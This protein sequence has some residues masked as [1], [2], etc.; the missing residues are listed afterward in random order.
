MDSRLTIDSTQL[1]RWLRQPDGRE[2]RDPNDRFIVATARRLNGM[3]LT[4][5]EEILEYARQ[6]QPLVTLP[7]RGDLGCQLAA[8]RRG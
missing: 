4:G 6:G 1:P 3:L 8:G 2:H 7:G 5:D